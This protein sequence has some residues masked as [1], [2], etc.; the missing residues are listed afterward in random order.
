MIES[1]LNRASIFEC[2]SKGRSWSYLR[3]YVLRRDR[4]KCQYCGVSSRRAYM[5]VDH[6]IPRSKGGM[7][8]EW[9]L[10][11]ACMPCNRR[12]RNHL[13]RYAVS[14]D[15]EASRRREAI[16]ESI[17]IEREI[18]A[19]ARRIDNADWMLEQERLEEMTS[20]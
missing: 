7:D 20:V 14:H 9:N 13:Y 4:Y 19:E 15:I 6:I 2:G 11:A 10:C 5:E 18:A 17:L 1:A 8:V 16:E 12:K 3:A